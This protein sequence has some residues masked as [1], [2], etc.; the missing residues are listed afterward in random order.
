MPKKFWDEQR[1]EELG[2][3]IQRYLDSGMV[4]PIE[5]VKEYNQLLIPSEKGL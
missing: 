1:K 2:S 5:W 4:I 3:A